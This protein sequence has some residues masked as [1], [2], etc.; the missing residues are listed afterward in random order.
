MFKSVET[1]LDPLGLVT[2]KPGAPSLDPAGLTGKTGGVSDIQNQMDDQWKRFHDEMAR[3][4]TEF[5]KA[6][7][8]AAVGTDGTSGANKA[9]GASDWVNDPTVDAAKLALKKNVPPA[10]DAAASANDWTYSSILVNT[11]SAANS[12]APKGSSAV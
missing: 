5:N 2:G 6:N 11:A 4:S 3:M 12:A 8:T 10:L 7:A 9:A 1:S